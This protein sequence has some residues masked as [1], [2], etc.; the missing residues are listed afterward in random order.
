ME[1]IKLK[2]VSSG[3]KTKKLCRAMYRD[4]AKNNK[5]KRFFFSCEG[6]NASSEDGN[7]ESD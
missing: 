4:E 6:M 5:C 3:L 7:D 1:K 2:T